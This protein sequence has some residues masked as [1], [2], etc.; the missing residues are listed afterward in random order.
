MITVE[1][2]PILTAPEG[3]VQTMHYTALNGN[4]LPQE[5]AVIPVSDRGFRYGDGVFDTIR[6]HQGVPYRFEW[7]IKRL[8]KGLKALNIVFDCSTLEA[9]CAGLLNKNQCTEG[10]LRIQITR[11]SGSKGYLPTE[12]IPTCVIE[13]LPLTP[14]PAEAAALW[15]SQYRRP[16]LTSLPMQSKLCQGLNSTLARMEAQEHDCFDALQLNTQGIICETSSANIFW[17]KGEILFTPALDAG[18]LEGA[19]RAALFDL[20]PYPLQEIHAETAKLEDAQAVVIC[21]SSWGVLPAG[22]LLPNG[23]RW[24][25]ESLAAILNERLRQNIAD[26]A[27]KQASGWQKA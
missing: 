3:Q 16:P 13:T 25:S 19:T 4:I 17:L 5:Q 11:G 15:L 23:W 26:Y 18:V 21:N 10:L 22:Q 20:S 24:N 2:Q 12:S 8:E 7:H 1:I 9:I 27:S 14:A 6:I